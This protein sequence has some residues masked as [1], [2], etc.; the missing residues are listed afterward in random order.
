MAAI[1]QVSNP[2]QPPEIRRLNPRRDLGR[3]ADLIELCFADTLDADGKRFLRRMRQATQSPQ[4]WWFN[5]TV[6][7]TNATADGYVWVEGR[8]IVGNINLVPFFRLGRPLYLIANVA[9]HPDFRRRGIARSLTSAALEWCQKRHVYSVWLQVRDI[10][11]PAVNLYKSAGF[12]ERT[13]RTTWSIQPGDIQGTP[14]PGVRIVSPKS[15][16]WSRQKKWLQQNYPDEIFWYWAIRRS[17]FWPGIL[18]AAL[19][20]LTETRIRHWGVERQDRLL[21]MLSWKATNTYTD[22]LWLAAPPETEDIVLQTLLPYI[23]WRERHRHPLCIDLPVGRAATT[24]Q[25][26]GFR[27][28]QT[29]IWMEK[30]A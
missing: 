5:T 1:S 20:F 13:R 11:P 21:G 12:I 7:K 22:Q 16:H 8:E 30:R 25:E 14:P 24:L 29:L 17:A 9:V 10:N 2:S 23:R 3:V 19:N 6:F 27:P 28:N 26:A 18:G 4:S 15:H